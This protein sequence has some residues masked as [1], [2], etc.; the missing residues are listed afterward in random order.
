M[1]DCDQYL[2]DPEAHAAH[3]E[4]CAEC[5]ALFEALDGE[6]DVVSRPMAVDALPVAPWEG[7]S[8]RTWPLVAVGAVSVLVLTTVLWI[9]TGLSPLKTVISSVPSFPALVKMLQLTGAAIGAP[10]VGLLF[11]AINSV[12]FFLLRRA[13]KGI[14]V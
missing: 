4:T 8:H 14:D 10:A 6:E 12:L 2:E 11:V 7:A 3:V 5:T 9:A 1:T 13:P